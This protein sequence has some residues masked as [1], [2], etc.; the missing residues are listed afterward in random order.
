MF[1]YRAFCLCIAGKITVLQLSALLKQ[2]DSS[3]HKLTLTR[4]SSAPIPFTVITLSGNPWNEDLL[5]VCGIKD[6]H[7]L[8][9]N[10]GGEQK[11]I[12]EELRQNY[13]NQNYTK[14][15]LIEYRIFKVYYENKYLVAIL[16]VRICK[17]A[18]F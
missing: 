8:T 5:A 2:A 10:S 15:K 13:T 14:K 7:V 18:I 1:V 12:S 17:A 6:C 9:F 4:L 16:F 3:K 11:I